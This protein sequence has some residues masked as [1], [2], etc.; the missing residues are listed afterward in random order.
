MVIGT[1]AGAM[2]EHLWL[3]GHLGH[4]WALFNPTRSSSSVK[5]GSSSKH[6]EE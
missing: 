2:L 6:N 3:L 1:F 5:K 4:L